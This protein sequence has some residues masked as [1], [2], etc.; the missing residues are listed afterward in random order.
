MD[1]FLLPFIF[2]I[3]AA[4]TLLLL[5]QQIILPATMRF[6]ASFIKQ[7]FQ[8]FLFVVNLFLT[9]K[10]G[11]TLWSIFLTVLCIV[12]IVPIVFYTFYKSIYDFGPKHRKQS[13]IDILSQP[14][15][16]IEFEEQTHRKTHQA[17]SSLRRR[18]NHR[19]VNC[20]LLRNKILS[21]KMVTRSITTVVYDC[22]MTSLSIV[23]PSLHGYENYATS[24]DSRFNKRH[25]D[26]SPQTMQMTLYF[27]ICHFLCP[28]LVFKALP[29]RPPDGFITDGLAMVTISLIFGL[30]VSR[31]WIRM[32]QFS[33]RQFIQRLISRE[34]RIY[35]T[36]H[37][38]FEWFSQAEP[39]LT[40]LAAYTTSDSL[41]DESMLPF[42]TDSSFWVCDN[43]ATGHIC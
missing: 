27:A 21:S 20:R 15:P 5:L 3:R 24:N 40:R 37:R 2:S 35:R 23:T 4:I 13:F 14:V 29:R 39:S 1:C 17:D 28:D 8:W 34:L 6:T 16:G 19:L 12:F 7:A 31:A 10:F 18:F 9:T 26:E 42:D 30:L 36:K 43:A 41:G 32:L 33:A 25:L 11:R 22:S 38:R